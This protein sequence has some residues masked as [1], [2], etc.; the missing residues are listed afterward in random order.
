MKKVVFLSAIFVIFVSSCGRF[1][2]RNEL[3]LAESL[4][5]HRPD[6]SLLIIESLDESVLSTKNEKALYAL[7]KSA[8]LD[9]NY[10]EIT[11]DSLTRVA[12]DY[13]S[14]HN[15]LRH[16]MMAHYYNALILNSAEDYTGASIA[17]EKAEK[18]ALAL[19][20][21]LYLGLV[22]RTM[23]DV[24]SRVNNNPAA[25]D[26]FQKAIVHFE[27]CDDMPDYAAY[28]KLSLA[29]S[30]INNKDYDSAS[31]ELSSLQESIG[32]SESLL[33]D[34]CQ[35]MNA[36]VLV[37][38]RTDMHK[39][40]QSFCSSNRDLLG[41]NEIGLFALAY[42]HLDQPDSTDKHLSLAYSLCVDQA[43]SATVDFMHAEIQHLR[44]N[45]LDA[46]KLTRKA[47]FAQDS[48][49]RT[50][51]QQS[52]S[53]AQRD[54]YKAESHMQE[55]KASRLRERN[56]FS[57]V[58]ALLVFILLSGTTF[59]Y[60]KR[61]EQEIKEQML[62]LSIAQSELRQAEKTN[63]SLLGSLFS[64]K[65]HHLDRLSEF[66]VH[67]DSDKERI[68][69]LKEFKEEIASMRT[70]E[71]LFLSLEKDLDHYCDGVMTKLRSQVQSIKGENLKLIEL[72]F[73]GLPY[74]TVQLVMNRV[75]IESLKTARSRF[76][77]EIKAANAPDDALFLKLLEMK[78]SRSV[79]Q[80]K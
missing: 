48:L 53:N 41:I 30:Y 68:I 74:S 45:D 28:A 80:E 23:G 17:L 73:A 75:S 39:A 49:T 15:D 16:R 12:V 40:V 4:L 33:N 7:L 5:Q 60:R 42:E 59:A 2:V 72:F 32:V 13:Y 47:A 76:R 31:K 67:A 10:I 54:Y 27:K 51:L 18:D 50:L 14:A 43:D 55:E 20:D 52:I 36:V 63:A 58:V 46:F 29:I 38:T 21:H 78:G 79:R 70:D 66:Y 8:A 3:R 9:K 56:L 62:E 44:G 65:L 26:Y 34:L 64:E 25:I 1:D 77:K 19:D 61:K 22:Y 71:D 69:A 11:S 37:K 24:F 35:I 57:L 6:S